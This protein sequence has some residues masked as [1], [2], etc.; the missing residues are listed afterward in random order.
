MD[1]INFFTA[2]EELA[3]FGY[4]ILLGMFFSAVYDLF[5]CVR[6][7]FPEVHVRLLVFLE[8][9]VYMLFCSVCYFVFVMEFSNGMIRLY[10]FAGN[11]A[12]FLF[13]H[14]TAGALLLK[15]V[16]GLVDFVKKHLISPVMRAASAPFRALFRKI[17]TKIKKLFCAKLQ[18]NK[19]NKKSRK[20]ALQ[21]DSLVVYNNS[22]AQS[23]AGAAGAVLRTKKTRKVHAKRREVS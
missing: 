1:N 16:R 21:V 18:N 5:R 22:G 7:G 3:A 15:F 12:G 13:W 8:D 9:V 20:K 19:K 11:A 2:S 6:A 17:V 10:I 14:Y 23:F 4:A